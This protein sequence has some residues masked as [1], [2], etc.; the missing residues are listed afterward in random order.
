M[1]AQRKEVDR[2]RTKLPE[3]SKL[4]I[5]S[6]K[7]RYTPGDNLVGHQVTTQQIVISTRRQHS[8]PL[9]QHAFNNIKLSLHFPKKTLTRVMKISFCPVI[10]HISLNQVDGWNGT[11]FLCT[12]EEISSAR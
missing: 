10:S 9:N 8:P 2:V 5:I 1:T 6:T 4:N 7:S 12:G 11:L 3:T